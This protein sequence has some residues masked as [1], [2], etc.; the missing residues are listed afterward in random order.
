MVCLFFFSSRR[1]HTRLQGDWSSD[2]C[3]SDLHDRRATA[4]AR[5]RAAG[6][7]PGHHGG[8]GAVSLARG[9]GSRGADVGPGG[10]EAARVPGAGAAARGEYDG[11]QGERRP[12]HAHGDR[13]EGRPREVSGAAGEPGVTPR[14]VVLS[15]PSG[16]G[17]TTIA[18][19]VRDRYPNRFGFSVSATT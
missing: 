11:L 10:G 8:A 3:S 15:A 19:A 6:G 5:D 9:G 2:V 12:H 1:R 13:H 7:P 16:G 14:L 17:K 4:R 18:K